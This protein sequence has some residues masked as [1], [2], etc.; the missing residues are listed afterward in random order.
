MT[1]AGVLRYV[2]ADAFLTHS[3]AS[4]AS[5]LVRGDVRVMTPASGSHGVVAGTIV[6]ALNAFVESRELGMCFPDNT[7][8]LLPGLGDTVRSPDVAFVRA[9]RLPAEGIGWD[10]LTVAPDLVVEILSPSETASALE[11]K[12]H[13]YRV[14]GTRLI[15]IV[16][17]VRRAVF[18]R[19]AEAAERRVLEG[20]VLD[21]TDVLP[22]FSM[23]VERLF[24]R[25]A[26]AT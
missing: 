5:E 3:A 4:G 14:S 22:G 21:A 18:I 2:T 12:L 16:D 17:P 11:E 26:R 20:D 23:P 15:W 1:S 19:S 8:F 24:A 6:A 10:W 25:L 13:D 7:G 9:E